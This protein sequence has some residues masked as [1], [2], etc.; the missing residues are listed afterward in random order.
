MYTHTHIQVRSVSE[1][2]EAA[3]AAAHRH[4]LE[5]TLQTAQDDAQ[6]AIS[7]GEWTLARKHLAA[8]YES[9]VLLQDASVE[10]RVQGMRRGVDQAQDS[11]EQAVRAAAAEGV[12]RE[13]ARD[14]S[15]AART[16]HAVPQQHLPRAPV[17][18]AANH[19][20]HLHER[21]HSEDLPFERTTR[22]V[23][24]R[25]APPQ[26]DRPHMS[27]PPQQSE[28]SQ[29]SHLDRGLSSAAQYL[30]APSHS[31]HARPTPDMMPLVDADTTIGRPSLGDALDD[32]STWH[33]EREPLSPS[34]IP[35]APPGG[36]GGG[37]MENSM[38]TQHDDGLLKVSMMG[39]DA[40]LLPSDNIAHWTET[41]QTARL[42]LDFDVTFEAQ[43]GMEDIS[44]GLLGGAMYG[45]ASL[46]DNSRRSRCVCV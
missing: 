29:Q 14:Q 26:P 42:P 36:W 16:H 30:T 24:V 39:H 21:V 8:A 19:D 23:A 10:E 31:M 38:Q 7:K 35:T 46:T 3:A 17:H 43:D 13:R 41:T 9:A 22:P 15:D 40:Q 32:D 20:A 6:E 12:D 33:Y 5:L 28:Y 18:D 44:G 25:A 4:D 34:L 1:Q 27:E 45:L 37:G 2:L 11:Y